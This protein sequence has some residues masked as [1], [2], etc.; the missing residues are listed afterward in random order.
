MAAMRPGYVT[1]VGY[2]ALFHRE[3]SPIWIAATLAAVG[4][5]MPDATAPMRYLDLGCGPGLNLALL[6]A[7]NPRGHFT[8]VDINPGHIDQAQRYATLLPNLEYRLGSFHALANEALWTEPFDQIVLHG[9]YSWIAPAQQQAVRRIIGRWLAPGGL[10]Y[11][12]YTSHPGHSAFAGA[13][14]L[15]RR[16]AAITPGPSTAG[17]ANGRAVIRA[18]QAGGAGYLQAQPAVARLLASGQGEDEDEAYLAHDLLAPHWAALHSAEVIDDMEEAGCAFIGSAELLENVDALSVPGA[19]LPLLAKVADLRT[20]ETIRD[21]ARNQ[22]KRRDLYRRGLAGLRPEAY[23]AQLGTLRFMA[24]PGAPRSG[25]LRMETPIGPISVDAGLVDPLRARLQAGPASFAELS[26]LVERG[27]EAAMVLRALLML[28]AAGETHPATAGPADPEPAQAL[29]RLLSAEQLQGG[30]LAAPAIGSAIP[31]D[32]M[33]MQV[34]RALLE[35][36]PKPAVD[37]HM[38]ARIEQ[39]ALPRWRALGVV[40][41]I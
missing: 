18:L 35:G 17:L 38:L 32:A 40:P 4:Q 22:S 15:L 41:E 10:V 39:Q 37:P 3:T 26:A 11:L 13:Q 30:W 8:G 9:V 31:L 16:V 2:P 24:L 25:D 14:A 7:A 6:A 27:A 1:D 36:L 29:N 12:H 23:R 34:A 19:L 21:L 33:G 20:R 28:V 5:A